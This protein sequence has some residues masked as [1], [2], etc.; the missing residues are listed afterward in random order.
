MIWFEVILDDLGYGDFGCYGN[1]NNPTPTVDAI[2]ASGIRYTHYRSLY[3]VCSPSRCVYETGQNAGFYWIDRPDSPE[4]GG[5]I[6]LPSGATTFARRLKT[7][8]PA[9]MVFHVGKWHLGTPGGNP[10]GSGAKRNTQHPLRF[11]NDHFFGAINGPSSTMNEHEIWENA[12]IIDD[13]QQVQTSGWIANVHA[14]RICDWLDAHHGHAGG[15]FI[16]WWLHQP[17][18]VLPSNVP[19][20]ADFPSLS[21]AERVYQANLKHADNALATV[22]S[23]L[24]ELELDPYIFVTSDNG[25]VGGE[26]NNGGLSGSKNSAREGGIRVPAILAGPEISPAVD[27]ENRLSTDVFVTKCDAFG[28]SSTGWPGSSLL[29]PPPQRDQLF[30]A[31]QSDALVR[32]TIGDGRTIKLLETGTTRQFFCVDELDGEQAVNELTVVASGAVAGELNQSDADSIEA[33]YDAQ[34]DAFPAIPSDGS[35]D[36]YPPGTTAAQARAYV[37]ADFAAAPRLTDY[38][39]FVGGGGPDLQEALEA[40]VP[41]PYTI[42]GTALQ[43]LAL[44]TLP[45]G[46][47]PSTGTTPVAFG[48]STVISGQLYDKIFDPAARANCSPEEIDEIDERLATTSGD[49]YL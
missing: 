24:D 48:A 12:W 30:R 42:P 35:Y 45:A 41:H 20:M 49:R 27:S 15:L 32:S 2:A 6:W 18:A 11:G 43:E 33:E 28:L 29:S 3:S 37:D 1:T 10:D 23:K 46:T 19:E 47:H 21:G 14:Q 26:A 13:E 4:T 40:L 22:I 9:P 38:R 39:V 31:V 44:G 7:L 5:R 34:Q 8:T 36:S 17:H 25:G 16:K